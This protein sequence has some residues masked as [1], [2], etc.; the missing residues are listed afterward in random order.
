MIFL[1]NQEPIVVAIELIEFGPTWRDP[2]HSSGNDDRARGYEQE[3][4]DSMSAD[5]DR[6]PQWDEEGIDPAG[7]TVL[8][9]WLDGRNDSAD[10]CARFQRCRIR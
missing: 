9:V 8:A 1:C 6:K 3:R 7:K 10:T 5:L 2:H 4:K